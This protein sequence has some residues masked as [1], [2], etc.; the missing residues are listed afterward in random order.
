MK[1]ENIL[2]IPQIMIIMGLAIAEAYLAY[3]YVSEKNIREHKRLPPQ[4]VPS[5]YPSQCPL[6]HHVGLSFIVKP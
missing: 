6:T 3:S 1:N 5:I 2:P 4:R